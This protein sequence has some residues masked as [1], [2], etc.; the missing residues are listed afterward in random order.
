[1]RLITD[2]IGMNENALT[3]LEVTPTTYGLGITM[4]VQ[5]VP[6]SLAC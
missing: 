5:G 2:F 4:K 6:V 3:D 1:M